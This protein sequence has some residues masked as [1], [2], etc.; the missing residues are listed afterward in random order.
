MKRS[1]LPIAVVVSL[2]V[3]FNLSWGQ[4]PQDPTDLGICDTLYV[5]TFG[6]DHVYDATGVY[7]SVRV[8]IYVTHDSNTFYWDGGGKYI[9]DSIAAFTIPLKF[10]KSGCADSVVFPTYGLWNNKY[11]SPYIPPFKRSIFRD[12]VDTH[13][14]PPETVYNRYNYMRNQLFWDAWTVQVNFTGDSTFF[15]MGATGPGRWWEGQKVLLATLTFLVYMGASCDSS[16]ICLDSTLWP[17]SSNLSFTRYDAVNYVPRHFLPIC[18]WVGLPLIVT[19]PNGGEV[20]GIGDSYDITWSSPDFTGSDVKIELSRDGGATWE[21]LIASTPN[22]GSWNWGPVTGPASTTCL[23]RVSDAADG[24]PSDISDANFTISG[25]ASITVTS[26]DGGESWEVGSAHDITWTWVGSFT[27]V[28]IELSRDGGSNWETL[29]ASTSNDGSWN[30]DPV[31]GPASTTCLVRISDAA[32]GDPTDMSDANFTIYQPSI[33]VTSPDG[34]ESWAVGSAHDIT[35]TWVGSFTDVK[36]ELSRD[37]GSNWETLIASTPNDGSWNWAPVT[38]PTSTTCRVRI[39]DTDGTPCDTSD[40]NFNIT[41]LVFSV[42]ASPDSQLVIQGDTAAFKVWVFGLPPNA[43]CTLSVF[44]LPPGAT[45]QF[46]PPFID[47][48]NDTSILSI[49]TTNATPEN[50]Y[51]IFIEARLLQYKPD[52][53]KVKLV[54]QSQSGVNDEN[55]QLIAPDKFALFQNQPNPFNPE[56]RISYYLSEACKVELSIYNVLGRKVKILF[57]G[58]QTSGTKTLVWDGK[59]DQG[60]QLSSGIYFYRLQAGTFSQTRKMSLIK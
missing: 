55:D 32:G 24:I 57:D 52:T 50:V 20:W 15:F 46:R 59:D 14:E 51:D 48:P 40:S 30:W 34:G 54:V 29:I 38:G 17:P 28:K 18:N 35:W 22:D 11:D 45:G 37:G 47:A 21:T 53:T 25:A 3:L 6:S 5:E 7:D 36:I 4:C 33:T 44:N 16:A 42:F 56:T 10:S 12:I 8:A 19:S 2:L 27:D 39:C 26:P 43:P 1:F 49:R 41:Q 23:V 9:Q 13:T 58:Y 31:T 60:N